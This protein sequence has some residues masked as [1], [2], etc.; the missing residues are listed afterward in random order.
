V[1]A[2]DAG[3]YANALART[4]EECRQGVE[5]FLEGKRERGQD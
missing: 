4:T 2:I 3:V 1:A 5:R